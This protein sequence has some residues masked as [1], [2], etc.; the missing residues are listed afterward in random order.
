MMN[1]PY[2]TFVVKSTQT[3][4]TGGDYINNELQTYVFSFLAKRIQIPIQMQP[5][6]FITM[7]TQ[8]SDE[9]IYP[10]A[11]QIELFIFSFFE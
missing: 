9:Q 5:Y 8:C 10:T 2:N 7:L 11:H 4:V 1:S 6:C 3:Q